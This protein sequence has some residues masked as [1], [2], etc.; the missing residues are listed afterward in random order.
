[1]IFRLNVI[2][3]VLQSA[4]VFTS[5][6]MYSKLIGFACLAGAFAVYLG[7]VIRKRLRQCEPKDIH[8]FIPLP[9][10]PKKMPIIGN[11]FDIPL[12]DM[13]KV[14]AEWKSLYG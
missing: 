12:V 7:Q 4:S 8:Q 2:I 3:K 6:N 14:F 10:G 13:A 5:I 1:M 11:L 9:P